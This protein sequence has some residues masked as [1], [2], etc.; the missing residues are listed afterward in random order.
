MGPLATPLSAA[1]LGIRVVTLPAR[2]AAILTFVIYE[3][4]LDVAERAALV[5]PA[6]PP[7]SEC[8]P[9][10]RRRPGRAA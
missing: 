7:P 4:L 6:D 2:A 5:E 8:G 10:P 1:R 9:S 3:E